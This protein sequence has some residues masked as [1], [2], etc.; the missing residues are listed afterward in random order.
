[1]FQTTN[2]AVYAIVIYIEGRLRASETQ[3]SH[4]WGHLQ[5][6]A[7]SIAIFVRRHPASIGSGQYRPSIALNAIRQNAQP[8][9]KIEKFL[10][11]ICKWAIILAIECAIILAAL[12]R[13]LGKTQTNW[14][15][16]SPEIVRWGW[17]HI[18]CL[19]C[20]SPAKLPHGWAQGWTLNFERL[21]DVFMVRMTIF[22]MEKP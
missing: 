1:M 4:H 6:R 22:P 13:R 14:D 12:S 17:N 21:K 2:Q 10:S 15:C 5:G 11:I 8:N 19:F 16:L 20:W 7:S 3:A 18:C 9:T